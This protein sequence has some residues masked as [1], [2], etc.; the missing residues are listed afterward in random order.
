[1]RLGRIELGPGAIILI[2]LVIAGLTYAGLKQMGLDLMK[3]LPSKSATSAGDNSGKT[4]DGKSLVASEMFSNSGVGA[5]PDGKADID[6]P[7][8]IAVVTWPGYAG[9]MLAN[10]GLKPN[11][12]SLYTKKY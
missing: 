1:M 2:V 5:S 10:G 4:A 11:S 8:K 7:I 9:G 12:D 3:Y 6:R